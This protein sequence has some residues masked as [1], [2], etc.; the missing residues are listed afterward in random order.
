MKYLI[1]AIIITLTITTIAPHVSS[2]TES[3]VK[4]TNKSLIEA[5]KY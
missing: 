4:M 3:S 2:F 5:D 1:A